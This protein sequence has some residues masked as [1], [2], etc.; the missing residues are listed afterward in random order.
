MRVSVSHTKSKAEVKRAVDLSFDD[1]FRGIGPLPIKIVNEKRS[2]AGDTLTFSFTA[3]WGIVSNPMSGTV[4]VT[5]RDI[6]IDADLGLLE[7][8]ISAAKG[9]EAVETRVRRLLT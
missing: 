6:T 1:L 2:W 7:K 8:L 5:E 9:R 4:V 3:R